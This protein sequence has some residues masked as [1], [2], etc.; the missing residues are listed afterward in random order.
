MMQSIKC[1]VLDVKV[2]AFLRR[3]STMSHVSLYETVKHSSTER[4]TVAHRKTMSWLSRAIELTALNASRPMQI[5]SGFQSM[6]FFLPVAK[7]YSELAQHADVYVFGFPDVTPPLIKNVHYI[8]LAKDDPLVLEWFIVVKSPNFSNALVTQ[9]QTGLDTPHA[10][11]VFRG[12]LTYDLHE[13][14]ALTQMLAGKL[15]LTLD[16]EQTIPIMERMNLMNM[17]KHLNY[18]IARESTDVV[19]LRELT[20]IVNRYIE[21]AMALA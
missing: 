11:R 17:V 18:A 1:M 9:D 5:F 15:S 13:V 2:I 10:R 14:N 7:R 16:P 6:Q 8:P 4:I 19:M 21:P 20:S 3:I 12:M